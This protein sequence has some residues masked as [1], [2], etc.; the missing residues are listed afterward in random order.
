MP[1]GISS[2]TAK[3]PVHKHHIYRVCGVILLGLSTYSA[4][5]PRVHGVSISH[6]Y[7]LFSLD[8]PFRSQQS[9]SKS[10]HH[11]CL[12]RLSPPSPHIRHTQPFRKSPFLRAIMTM[13]RGT[14]RQYSSR[15]PTPLDAADSSALRLHG[16]EITRNAPP[17]SCARPTEIPV[18]KGPNRHASMRFSR[19]VVPWMEEAAALRLGP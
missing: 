1:A 8:L 15:L 14:N 7:H 12:M 16:S 13:L 11:A 18:A 5:P 2:L 4:T 9:T 17:E 3:G 19:R 6:A 10:A